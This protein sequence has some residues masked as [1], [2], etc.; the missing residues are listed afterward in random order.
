MHTADVLFSNPE[1]AQGTDQPIVLLING[2]G[3]GVT[4][5]ILYLATR[6]V[7]ALR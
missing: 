7:M 3:F 5:L 1:F 6:L 4:M 2:S